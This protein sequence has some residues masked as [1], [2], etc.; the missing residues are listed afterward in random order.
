MGKATGK[1]VPYVIAPR[2]PGDVAELYADPKRAN[3]FLKW[4]AE[5]GVG[6]M[7]EHTWNWQ[8]NNPYGYEQVLEETETS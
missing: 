5:L 8:S 6:E 2:R 1:A 4:K 3:E 7:C